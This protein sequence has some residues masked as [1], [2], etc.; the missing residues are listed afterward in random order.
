MDAEVSSRLGKVSPGGALLLIGTQTLEQSL[1]IDADWLVTDLSPIDVLL[2]RIGR[3]HRHDRPRPAGFENARALVRIPP[4]G[5]LARYLKGGELKGPAGLGTVYRDGRVLQRTLD[6]L[7]DRPEIVIPDD[8]RWLVEQ[9]TH[10]TA[11]KQVDEPWLHH[12]SW[13]TGPYLEQVRQAETS[14]L[15]DAPF[16]ELHYPAAEEHVRTRLGGEALEIPLAHPMSSPFG[17]LIS[18]LM[19]PDHMKPRGVAH[20]PERI[21][22]DKVQ[23][24]DEGFRFELCGNRYRYTRVGLEKDDA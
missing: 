23:N 22:K 24:F 14:T 5:D 16:G 7:R 20:W 8:N 10:P 4:D 3:L 12:G 2:Q 21:D 1:D 11:L 9:C 18:R 15:D 13:L 17:N 19:I 6:V